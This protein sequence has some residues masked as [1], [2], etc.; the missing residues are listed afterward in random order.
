MYIPVLWVNLLSFQLQ[1]QWAAAYAEGMPLTTTT[2]GH[3][4]QLAVSRWILKKLSMVDY[5]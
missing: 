1:A 4:V 2:L 5:I 3:G